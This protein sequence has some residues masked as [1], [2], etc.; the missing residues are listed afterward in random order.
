M[1]LPEPDEGARKSQAE[2]PQWA[3]G[4]AELRS[5]SDKELVRQHDVK[6]LGDGVDSGTCVGLNYYLQELARRDSERQTKV[7]LRL[8]WFIAA[9][10]LVMV[11]VVVLSVAGVFD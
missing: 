1:A 4:L 11:A 7:M 6:A 8:T 2:S 5:L 10:T 3:K 9:L